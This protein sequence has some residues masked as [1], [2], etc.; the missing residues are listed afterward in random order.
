MVYTS[1]FD[2]FSSSISLEIVKHHLRH[3]W[4]YYHTNEMYKR[5]FLTR[6]RIFCSYYGK[7]VSY[8]EAYEG[9]DGEIHFTK[10]KRIKNK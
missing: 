3:Q 4:H 2:N 5:N 9:R 7:D 10:T 6:S 8:C 1:E